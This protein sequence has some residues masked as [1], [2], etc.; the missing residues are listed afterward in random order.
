MKRGSLSTPLQP[1][2]KTPAAA[3]GP[4]PSFCPRWAEGGVGP[5]IFQPFLSP[6]CSSSCPAHTPREPAA[7]F[8]FVVLRVSRVYGKFPGLRDSR[9]LIL[10]W[11]GRMGPHSVLSRQESR[12]FGQMVI[13]ANIFDIAVEVLL[14]DV[15]HGN[16]VLLALRTSVLP[17]R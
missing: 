13:F 17:V 2:N 8:C 6:S 12:S 9:S 5:L 1:A 10:M 11:P 3:P 15:C 4:K 7:P 16:Y 14:V